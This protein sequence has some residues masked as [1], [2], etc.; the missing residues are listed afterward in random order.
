VN[1]SATANVDGALAELELIYGVACMPQPLH[2]PLLVTAE[3]AAAAAPAAASDPPSRPAA[4]YGNDAA[5]ELL[6][7]LGGRELVLATDGC[8]RNAVQTALAN[9]GKIGAGLLGR[10]VELGG[11]EGCEAVSA[12]GQCAGHVALVYAAT[13][14][15]RVI[16]TAVETS[17]RGL[18]GEPDTISLLR[19]LV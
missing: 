16:T 17:L 7:E 18:A 3:P 10:I 9:A 14:P 15:D 6:L 5:V 1:R 12:Y 8:G 19:L 2:H 11:R 13:L 4:D